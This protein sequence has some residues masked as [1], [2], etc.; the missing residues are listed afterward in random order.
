VGKYIRVGGVDVTV[1]VTVDVIVAACVKVGVTEFC[2]FN[3]DAPHK[4]TNPRQ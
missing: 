2:F 1:D 3:R 4:T